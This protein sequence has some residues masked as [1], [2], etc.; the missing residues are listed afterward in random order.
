M[1]GIEFLQRWFAFEVR[2]LYET[3]SISI[4]AL[5]PLVDCILSLECLMIS[6]KKEAALASPQREQQC[7]CTIRCL[8][9]FCACLSRLAADALRDRKLVELN[10]EPEVLVLASVIRWRDKLES[11]ARNESQNLL[12]TKTTKAQFFDIDYHPH[13]SLLNID[14]GDIAFVAMNN[15]AVERCH[16]LIFQFKELRDAIW[17][18]RECLDHIDAHLDRDETLTSSIKAFEL[19]YLHCKRLILRPCNLV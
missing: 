13:A 2:Y 15:A 9:S 18:R 8:Q 1:Q 14:A 12:M 10:H 16:N 5:K 3:E 19:A 7:L 17:G 11:D 6:E 4:R